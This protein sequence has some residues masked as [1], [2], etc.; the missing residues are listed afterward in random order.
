MI[1]CY[2]INLDRSPERWEKIQQAPGISRLNVIRV[3]AVDGRQLTKPYTD[4]SP[5][6]YF[7]LYGR[8]LTPTTVA[9][10]LSHIK[11]LKLFL[12]SDQEHALICEDDVTSVPEL[13]EIIEDVL[14]FEDSIDFVRFCA[15]RQK[16]YIAF[17]ALRN[18]Y[19]LVSDLGGGSSN[20]GYL[21]NRKAAQILLKILRPMRVNADVAIYYGIPNGIREATI[22]PLPITL[23]DMSQDSTIGMSPRYPWLHP[24]IVRHVTVL[25]YKIFTRTWRMLHRWRVALTRK[26]WP[27]KP[28]VVNSN[29]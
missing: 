29:K 28:K 9:C 24:A 11:V 23:T 18:G 21:V 19:K 13:P 8:I 27:P 17:A 26:W 6:S 14:K 5:W 2:I 22:A 7:F 12:E 15:F 20:G 10:N 3:P 4:F 16:P 25:P 1:D